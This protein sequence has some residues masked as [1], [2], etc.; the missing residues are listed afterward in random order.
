MSGTSVPLETSS[1]AAASSSNEKKSAPL[2]EKAIAE[3]SIVSQFPGG[4]TVLKMNE[5]L[6]DDGDGDAVDTVPSSAAR[7]AASKNSASS[8]DYQG[9][10]VVFPDGAEGIVVA[11]RPP[12]VFCYAPKAA[13]AT[14]QDGLVKIF[15]STCNITVTPS[16]RA[17]DCFG[18]PQIPTND[19]EEEAG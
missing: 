1:P 15:K 13:T 10:K 11:H 9:K 5:D 19:A 16:V 14:V 4:L 6:L 8:G 2:K 18:L 7:T 3:G 17:L 12:I